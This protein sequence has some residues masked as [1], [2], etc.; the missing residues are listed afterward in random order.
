MAVAALM[1]SGC[2]CGTGAGSPAVCGDPRPQCEAAL[3]SAVD[4]F[5]IRGCEKAIRNYWCGVHAQRL[6]ECLRDAAVC[7]ETPS[8]RDAVKVAL[9]AGVCAAQFQEWDGC[10]AN[11]E[12]GGGDFDD[13]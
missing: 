11:G 5:S 6:A 7:L 8:T 3:A 4:L 10:Y 1:L 12:A 2:H 13:D 9:A